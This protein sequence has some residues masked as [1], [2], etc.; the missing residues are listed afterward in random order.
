[1]RVDMYDYLM[2]LHTLLIVLCASA[3]CFG[4]CAADVPVDPLVDIPSGEGFPATAAEWSG[5]GDTLVELRGDTE[6]VQAYEYA[7]VLDPMDAK[8]WSKYGQVLVKEDMYEQAREAYSHALAMDPN[9]ADTWNNLGSL[10]FQ[11]GSLAEAVAAFEQAIA[12]DPGYIPQSPHEERELV[13]HV[14][15]SKSVGK[16][17]GFPFIFFINDVLIGSG[18]VVIV[19]LYRLRRSPTSEDENADESLYK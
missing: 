12:L 15:E 4:F 6:A 16:D 1:M 14:S 13:E 7:L 11:M 5:L 10:L 17:A 8:T 2:R 9:D 3:I 18:V 19:L